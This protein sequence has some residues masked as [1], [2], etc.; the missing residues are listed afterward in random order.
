MDDDVDTDE[1]IYDNAMGAIRKDFKEAKKDL[2]KYGWF[3]IV[4]NRE[5]KLRVA[6]PELYDRNGKYRNSRKPESARHSI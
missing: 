2:E 3:E 4:N 1:E 6:N 5:I